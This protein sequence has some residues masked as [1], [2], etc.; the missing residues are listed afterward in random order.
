MVRTT[1]FHPQQDLRAAIKHQLYMGED[2]VVTERFTRTGPDEILYQFTVSDDSLYR[3]DW[4]GE[5]T[6]RRTES[7]IYEYAC[8]EGNYSLPNILAGARQQ[9][10]EE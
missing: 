5:M 9:E 1:Q 8:H 3:Q 2:T 6:L 10:Q 4:K 7:Q